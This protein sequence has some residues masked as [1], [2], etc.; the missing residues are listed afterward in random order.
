MEIVFTFPLFLLSKL[1]P[2]DPDSRKGGQAHRFAETLA[3]VRP[4]GILKTKQ[5]KEEKMVG[6]TLK[7]YHE[8]WWYL[9]KSNLCSIKAVILGW[10]SLA[11]CNSSVT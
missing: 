4:V 5:N 8:Y 11:F 10:L 6:E 7:S 9:E 1:Y 3:P 2:T